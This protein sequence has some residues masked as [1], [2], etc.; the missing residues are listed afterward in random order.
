[1]S[2]PLDYIQKYPERT[3]R[4][5]GISYQQWQQLTEKAIAYCQEQQNR[6]EKSKVRINAQGGGRKPILS[7]EEEICL[8]LFYLRQMPTF[9]VLGIQFEISKTE[10]N[11][12]FHKWLQIL[13]KLLPASL[14]EELINQPQ[15]R[16][17]LSELLTE[18]EL[19]VDTTEQV[20][21]R[22]QNYQEQKKYFSGKQQSHTFKPTS[23][24]PT[25]EIHLKS[26]WKS[27]AIKKKNEYE[28]LSSENERKI[29]QARSLFT[30]HSHEAAFH[31]NG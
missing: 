5:L 9:E 8:C 3:T 4:I 17:M 1:M 13:R 20:R 18:I 21:E 27:D 6:L 16:E 14:L 7:Q 2:N 15:N 19:L 22:P 11:D 23:I 12:T 29:A 24:S 10:A 31:E 30:P 28:R 26:L 25:N